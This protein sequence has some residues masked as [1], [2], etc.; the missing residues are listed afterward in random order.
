[1]RRLDAERLLRASPWHAAVLRVPGIYAANRLP[2]ERLRAAIPVPFAPDDVYTNHIHAEDLARACIAALYRATSG[3]V[4]NVIDDTEMC[5]GEYL[6]H[7][8]DRTGLP[9]PPRATWD[10]MRLAAGPLRMSFLSESRRLRN[11]RLKRELRLRLR[12]PDVTDGLADI[13]A[14]AYASNNPST[15]R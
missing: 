12:F 3:R 14:A 10:Q 15:E 4:Y 2:L 6:D 9:R 1:M 5:L 7:V 11:R 13:D 8:A